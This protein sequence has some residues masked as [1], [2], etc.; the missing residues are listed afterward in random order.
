MAAKLW[1]LVGLGF[2][3]GVVAALAIV[4]ALEHDPDRKPGV[5]AVAPLAST[6]LPGPGTT[7]APS[8]TPPP[9]AAEPST[10]TPQ[11]SCEQVRTAGTYVDEAERVRFLAECAAAG[12][13][14]AASTP[15]GGAAV[16]VTRSPDSVAPIASSPPP[17]ISGRIELIGAVWP[18]EALPVRYCVNPSEIPVRSNGSKLISDSGFAQLVQNAFATWQSLP[19]SRISFAYQGLCASDPWDNHD[20]VN[21]VGWGW[22]FGSAIGLADPSGTNGRFLRQ[23]STGQLFEVD[24]VIDI[25]YAQ[26]F[27]DPADYLQRQLPHIL[28]HETGHFIGLGHATEPCSVMRPSGIGSGLCWVDIAAAA[29]L[30]PR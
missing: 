3:A 12:P 26:S 7:V 19:E 28:L 10:P 21:T 27:D 15:V 16:V 25:R 18:D 1:L 8:A 5:E 2:G 29:L 24:L 13:S 30:Y 4:L 17:D 11:R 20:G 23:N 22:L 6:M 14:P 9:P